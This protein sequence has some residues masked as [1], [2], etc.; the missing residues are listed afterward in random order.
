MERE[1]FSEGTFGRIK[2][3]PRIFASLIL[4]SISIAVAAITNAG[5]K[6]TEKP[7]VTGKWKTTLLTDPWTV[8]K[9]YELLFELKTRDA[10]LIGVV[11]ERE[12]G[13]LTRKAI[14]DG[15]IQGKF[16]S[17]YTAETLWTRKKIDPSKPAV[18]E[19]VIYKHF[20]EGTV[21]NDRIQFMKYS[22]YPG[23]EPWEF[24]ALRE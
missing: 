10:R 1:T 17:F 5:E 18:Q 12:S 20:Y 24:E 22:D 7:D 11:S 2:S 19:Q 3:H 14:L 21:L 13:R 23:F 15:K 16:I 9:R 6:V 8:D 4:V